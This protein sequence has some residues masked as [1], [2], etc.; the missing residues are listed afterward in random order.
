MSDSILAIVCLLMISDEIW[1][2]SKKMVL[3]NL[4]LEGNL[5]IMR[6][7]TKPKRRYAKAPLK[8]GKEVCTE[9]L[10][11]RSSFLFS[12]RAV[13]RC[14]IHFSDYFKIEGNLKIIAF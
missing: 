5:F 2:K 7:K 12:L 8:R 11:S 3:L 14:F 9:F 4:E 13:S 10:L 1:Q 6:Q